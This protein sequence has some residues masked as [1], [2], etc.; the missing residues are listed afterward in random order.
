M[1]MLFTWNS[2][3]YRLVEF[4]GLKMTALEMCAKLAST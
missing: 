4:I 2:F 1:S 3:C